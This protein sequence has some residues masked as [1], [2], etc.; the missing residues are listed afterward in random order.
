MTGNPWCPKANPNMYKTWNHGYAIGY[1][2]GFDRAVKAMLKFI[3]DNPDSTVAL[4][5]DHFEKVIDSE[6]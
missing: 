3:E 4:F 5:Y 2:D 6:P 1:M